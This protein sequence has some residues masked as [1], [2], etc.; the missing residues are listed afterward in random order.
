MDQYYPAGRVSDTL[1]PELNRRLRPEEFWEA[2][3]LATVAGLRRLDRRAPHPRLRR[4]LAALDG[5]G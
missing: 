3:R 1:Y 2:Q 5:M 4:R